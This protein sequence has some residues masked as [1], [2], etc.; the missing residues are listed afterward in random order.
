MLK[1][2]T[3]WPLAVCCKDR[4]RARD[5]N[6]EG[7]AEGIPCIAW[8]QAC[9][10][11]LGSCLMSN[12]ASVSCYAMHLLI[13][14]VALLQILKQLQTSP[15]ACQLIEH[16]T[17]Q[18]HDYIVMELLGCNAVELR[19]SQ[20]PRGRWGTHTVKQLGERAGMTSSLLA[21]CW[22]M[23]TGSSCC[24]VLRK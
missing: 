22:P 20:A 9:R 15:H 13:N 21:F 14:V 4:A 23:L 1:D 6:L 16:G 8:Q 11:L 10:H 17:H 5:Q 18:G 12:R 19:K 24:Q 3:T 7:R 2:S